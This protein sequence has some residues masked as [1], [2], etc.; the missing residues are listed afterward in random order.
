MGELGVELPVVFPGVGVDVDG[1]L[2]YRRDL[3]GSRGLIKEQERREAE[4]RVPETDHE[5]DEE[6]D[7]ADAGGAYPQGASRFAC[8]GGIL[9]RPGVAGEWAARKCLCNMFRREAPFAR[10]S[11]PNGWPRPRGRLMGDVATRN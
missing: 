9:N 1:L 6:R 4:D 8:A 10:D 3:R 7:G 2:A 11:A 5:A